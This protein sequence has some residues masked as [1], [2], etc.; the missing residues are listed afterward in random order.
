VAITGPG[1]RVA[2]VALLAGPRDQAPPDLPRD[3]V[4]PAPEFPGFLRA[5]LEH[6]V[7]T[8]SIADAASHYVSAYRVAIKDGKL[9]VTA[10]PVEGIF[11]GGRAGRA[12]LPYWP[13]AAALAAAVLAGAG[14]WFVRRRAT[15]RTVH[16]PEP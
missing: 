11:P 4:G 8:T 6:P 16:A 12:L 7:T 2:D 9:E 10:L 1:R 14:V 5:N 15:R 3:A 13:A